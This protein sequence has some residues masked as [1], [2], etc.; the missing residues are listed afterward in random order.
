MPF[1]GKVNE[2]VVVPAE[3]D[4]GTGVECPEC[5]GTMF[6]REGNEI[7]RHFYHRD[8]EIDCSSKG[9][10]DIHYK[11]KA[12]AVEALQ[13][14]WGDEVI[15]CGAEI[16]I[17]VTFSET[18]ASRRIADALIEFEARNEF[19]GSGLVIEVQ[20]KNQEKDIRKTTADYI[21]ADYSVVWLS[22]SDFGDEIL[23]YET[24]GE[25]FALTRH[26]GLRGF[27][28][29]GYSIRY[30]PPDSFGDD[31]MPD[32]LEQYQRYPNPRTDVSERRW[33]FMKD[34]YR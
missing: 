32:S 17:D 11:C 2:K 1:K 22:P 15:R 18:D 25:R 7:A 9:E 26:Q 23:R 3:V 19:F 8:S 27:P 13:K 33:S 20:H 30:R 14:K 5:G 12:L 6:P 24:I 29:V 21:Q 16:P 28:E 4:N 34:P 10:S 31:L